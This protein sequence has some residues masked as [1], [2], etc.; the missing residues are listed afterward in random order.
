M[1]PDQPRSEKAMTLRLA[2]RQAAEIEK[3]AQVEDRPVSEAIRSAIDAYIE[4]RRNDPD[5]QARLRRIL[6]EDREILKRLA[7]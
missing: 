3:V 7:K 1:N 4:Q 6:D 2:G 5:F